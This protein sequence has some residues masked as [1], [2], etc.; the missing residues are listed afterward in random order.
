MDSVYHTQNGWKIVLT[1]TALTAVGHVIG[2]VSAGVY[3][4]E[5]GTQIV[6]KFLT[7]LHLLYVIIGGFLLGALP[8][9]LLAQK[10]LITPLVSGVFF[11]HLVIGKW[12]YGSPGVENTAEHFYVYRSLW[13]VI[14]VFLIGI[15]TVEYVARDYARGLIQNASRVHQ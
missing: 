13:P 15:G 6:G 9:Y 11:F 5:I 8:G 1:V 7:D 4:G 10:R 14:A 2:V 12:L 3:A